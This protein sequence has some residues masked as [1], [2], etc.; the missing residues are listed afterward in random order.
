MKVTDTNSVASQEPTLAERIAGWRY[1]GVSSFLFALL[2][3]ICPALVAIGAVR[4]FIGLGAL[5]AAAGTSAPLR[6][7]H[8]DS[9]RIPV[10]LIAGLGA[11][12]NLF[13][14]WHV[15]RL[16]ARPAAQWRITPL[17]AGKLRGERVQIVLAVL[18][19]VCLA[20][21]EITHAIL[22]H[23]HP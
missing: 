19:F 4:V 16:R 10:M 9:I 18:T 1:L 6:V 21:E 15:R 13:V 11:A 3:T 22:H 12:L 5:A 14:I 17:T 8:G 2:Q 7:W 23:P 20:A